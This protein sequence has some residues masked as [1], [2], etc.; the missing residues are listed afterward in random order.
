MN[1]K[2]IRPDLSEIKDQMTVRG[3]G[4]LRKPVPPEQTN[5]ESYYYLKQMTNKT[6]M[7]IVLKDGEE[8]RGVI[9]WYDK[10]ALKVH[11]ATLPNILLLKDNVKYMY[12]ENEDKDQDQD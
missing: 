2:L 4:R 7:V 9:E 3:A 5:A 12:K 11:R 6:K 8:V 1:R 10:H